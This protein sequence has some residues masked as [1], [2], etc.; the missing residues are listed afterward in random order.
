MKSGVID[1]THDLEAKI[2]EEIERG[3]IINA[4]LCS[5]FDFLLAVAIVHM[6]GSR[7]ERKNRL[8][9]RIRKFFIYGE[10]TFDLSKDY[11]SPRLDPNYQNAGTYP[12]GN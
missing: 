9:N 7:E 11:F 3:E 10:V 4:H 1:L 12:L 5:R 8:N 2:N 6:E